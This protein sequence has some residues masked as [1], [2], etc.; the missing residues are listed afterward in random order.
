MARR[1]RQTETT[2]LLPFGALS[3]CDLLSNHW[4]EHRLPLEPEWTELRVESDAALARATG[5]WRQER[6][7]VERY[8][9]EPSMEQ[10]FI[11]PMLEILGWKLVYQTWLQGR[12]PDYALFLDDPSKDAA[13]AAGRQA[14]E[15][16]NHPAILA[17]AKAW[18]VSL[19]R[20][21]REGPPTY[22]PF[23]KKAKE[24]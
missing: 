20:P 15:F 21:A 16:W 10:A 5:L 12:K 6:S 8:G 1:R 4:L 19:D 13:I 2:P 22:G 17:D 18:H 14:P 3:N 11:Q 9:S 7:R 24:K 23:P